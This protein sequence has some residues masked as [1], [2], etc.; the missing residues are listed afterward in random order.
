[1]L[2]TKVI[3]NAKEEDV[4][5]LYEKLGEVVGMMRCLQKVHDYAEHNWAGRMSD[6]NERLNRLKDD[7][8]KLILDYVETDHRNDESDE[9]I[10]I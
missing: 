4:I 5:E 1:M 9:D 8:N 2:E 10:Y 3:I 6:V 7:F